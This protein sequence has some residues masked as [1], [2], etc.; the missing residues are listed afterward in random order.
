[1]KYPR[2]IREL[3]KNSFFEYS[4]RTAVEYESP[5]C[6]VK[7]SY[8][9]LKNDIITIGPNIEK[10]VGKNVRLGIIGEN[11]YDWLICY[12]TALYF[13]WILVPLDKELSEENLV[14]IICESN[15][16]IIA[17]GNESIEKMGTVK[18]KLSCIFE[19]IIL[20]SNNQQYGITIQS[21]L[22]SKS[23]KDNSFSPIVED[24]VSLIYFTSGTTSVSKG[25]MLSQKNMIRDVIGVSDALQFTG[26]NIGLG[27]LPFHHVFAGLCDLLYINYIGGTLCINKNIRSLSNDIQKYNPTILFVVPLIAGNLLKKASEKLKK[28]GLDDINHVANDTEIFGKRLRT[29]ICAGAMISSDM[30]DLYKKIGIN[31]VRG[32][33]LTEASGAVS[34]TC[35]SRDDYDHLTIGTPVSCNEIKIIDGEICVR[36][37]N[38]MIGYYN[39]PTATAETFYGK[40]LRTGDLGYLDEKGDLYI[41]GRLKNLIILDNGKNIY[42]EELEELLLANDEIEECMVCEHKEDSFTCIAAI[43]RPS[44]KLTNTVESHEIQSVL[45]IL[46]SGINK[47]LPIY[48]RIAKIFLTDLEFEKTATNKIIRSKVYERINLKG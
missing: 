41:T 3:L 5:F 38:I 6:P 11:S 26:E 37:D 40:W 25:I 44:S 34:I 21:I 16:N 43:I 45:S 46:L 28:M 39:N 18:L 19:F 33:G 35:S 13:G 36:G 42:P 32:Y 27:V 7:K 10:I 2:N 47:K 24:D 29:I 31:V 17:V 22:S 48:K 12:F 4:N 30:V 14:K 1:M 9:D 15:I 23:S 8:A 20:N